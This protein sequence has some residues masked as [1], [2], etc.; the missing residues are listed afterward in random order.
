M[1]LDFFRLLQTEPK[2][3]VAFDSISFD[4]VIKHFQSD[5][6][7]RNVAVDGA[8]MPDYPEKLAESMPKYPTLFPSC[9]KKIF[10]I[11][12]R[13]TYTDLVY[14][15]MM[16]RDVQWHQQAGNR[17]V[18]AL[19]CRPRCRRLLGQFVDV[20]CEEWRNATASSRR[21]NEFRGSGPGDNIEIELAIDCVQ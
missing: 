6:K 19:T 20:L 17:N 14:S 4:F 21:C 13:Q 12:P 11:S 10:R 16:I 5:F 8:I 1:I 15:L 2:D 3:L 18:W 7:F 9:L